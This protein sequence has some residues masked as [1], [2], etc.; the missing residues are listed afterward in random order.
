MNSGNEI[1]PFKA[2]EESTLAHLTGRD[3]LRD[4]LLWYSLLGS[5]GTALGVMG[6]G[7]AVNILQSEKGWGFVPA[8]RVIFYA[9]AGVGL[10]KFVFAVVLSGRVEADVKGKKTKQGQNAGSG[11]TQPLL[12][13]QT[14]SDSGSARPPKPE[15]KSIFSFLG[16]K[17]T[18]SLVLR[19]FILFGLDSFASGLAPL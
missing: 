5:A 11:E 12:R 10:V 6:C 8:C 3:S 17:E 2:V 9:Y 13:E 16:E 7:W 14:E 19:L 15:R 18:V 1:G 4:V